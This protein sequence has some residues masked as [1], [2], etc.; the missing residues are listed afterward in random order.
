MIALLTHIIVVVIIII[1]IIATDAYCV[2][3]KIFILRCAP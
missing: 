3:I 2:E 1:I